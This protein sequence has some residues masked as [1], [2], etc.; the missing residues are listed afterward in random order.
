MD[1]W[2]LLMGIWKYFQ[3][4]LISIVSWQERNIWGCIYLSLRIMEVKEISSEGPSN[5]NCVNHISYV[6][7]NIL[8]KSVRHFPTLCNLL[9]FDKKFILSDALR[10]RF[11][12]HSALQPS[13]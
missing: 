11:S 7:R 9:N 2:L 5:I 10:G 12:Y 1:L 8:L 3:H 6:E 4:L 13:Y